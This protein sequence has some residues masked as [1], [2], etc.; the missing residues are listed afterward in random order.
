MSEEEADFRRRFEILEPIG[1]GTFGYVVKARNV[2]T[3]VICA[4]KAVPRPAP[5]D[6]ESVKAMTREISFAKTL[7][8]PNISKFYEVIELEG[9]VLFVMEILEGGSLLD[10]ANQQGRLSEHAACEIFRQLVDGLAYMH[11]VA[12]VV[13][14]DIKAEN[15]MFDRSMTPK[16]IDFGLART[17]GEG[18]EYLSTFCG[19]MLYSSP[20]MFGN[21]RQYYSSTDIW[22]MGI[23]LYAV[24][25]GQ[26]PFCSEAPAEI[27]R[28]ITKC[29]PEFPTFLSPSVCDLMGRMLAKNPDDRITIPEIREHA[30]LMGGQ[31]NQ[32]TA[33]RIERSMESLPPLEK[34][35]TG[36][37]PQ[38]AKEDDAARMMRAAMS[39]AATSAATIARRAAMRNKRV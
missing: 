35:P 38:R 15:I 28:L 9:E 23:L 5:N 7:Y 14:R 13:H 19:S 18:E 12:K 25:V 11:E 22:S 34:R 3:N 4:V 17:F 36:R 33:L 16:F 37:A 10:Y 32:R 2:E 21:D 1:Q 20:E 8:H 26:L 30:W 27:V 31:V 24:V 6:L 39:R 29:E